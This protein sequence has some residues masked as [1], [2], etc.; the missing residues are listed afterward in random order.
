MVKPLKPVQIVGQ[1]VAYLLF[2]AVVGYLSAA[3]AYTYIDPEKAVVKLSFS[4]AGAR[5]GECRRLTPEEIAKLAPNMR[6]ALDCPRE[7]V[8]L[9]VEIEMDGKL[10][11]QASLAPTGLARDGAASVYERFTID[12]GQHTLIARLRDS[13]RTEGFDYKREA[14][15][16]LAPQQNFVIDFRA[17]TGGFILR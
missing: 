17:E 12:P 11:Y 13:R 15:I 7:R 6:R 14:G 2:A 8:E 9:L 5:K 4:H 1:A 16:T 10:L 3:P